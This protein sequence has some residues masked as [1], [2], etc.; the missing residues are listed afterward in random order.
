MSKYTTNFK[1]LV[2]MGIFSKAEIVAWF[3]DYEL[4]DFLTSDEINI[5]NSRGTW[6]KEKLAKRIVDEYYFRDIGFETPNLFKHYAKVKMLDI[7]ESKLPLIYSAS[8][9][10][11]PLVNV[12]YHETLTRNVKADANSTG[13]TIASDTPQGQID[14]TDIL[15]GKYASQTSGD[16]S[17]GTTN[18]DETYDKHVI[19]NS[20]VSATAQAMVKQYRDNIRAIDY[21]IIKEL[22]DL[23]MGLF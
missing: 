9:S 3:T 13:L 19:G 7:M 1:T 17:S 16:E 20:G 6:N 23:F 11:D 8:I 10:Y 2:N 22:N 12:N 21:E 18:Q 15:S 14:K 5:I 4:S